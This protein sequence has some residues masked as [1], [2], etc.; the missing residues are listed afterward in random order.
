MPRVPRA[1]SAAARSI[2][3]PRSATSMTRAPLAS[4][5]RRRFGSAEG[6]GQ[7]PNRR[8]A[9]FGEE[10]R[11]R[12]DAQLPVDDDPHRRA[13]AEPIEPAG[14]L[15]VVGEHGADANHDRIVP[16]AQ[17]MR[18]GARR[19]SGN[20]AA[21]APR[22]RDPPV[23]RGRELHRDERPAPP[24]PAEKPGIDLGR[25]IGA[26]PD[27]G[28]DPGG[29]QPLDPAAAD[30]RIR[31]FDRGDDPPDPGFDQR[32][33]ARR[34]LAPVAARFE[35]DIGGG[36]AGAG[37]GAGQRLGLGVRPAARLGPA[38]AD[39]ASFVDQNAADRRVGPSIAE[40]APGEP[41]CRPHM[42]KI[43]AWRRPR[44]PP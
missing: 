8:R 17:Q 32:L 41:Q 36:A 30:A 33:G 35:A 1:A 19:R 11:R 18:P 3:S 15:R 21:L 13:P 40:A 6:R 43:A 24:Y 37:A 27:F 26:E 2:P 16:G 25:R 20:P 22:H 14:E 39:D 23:E 5:A 9:G 29:A 10:P 12:R 31:V 28:R 7:Q 4:S 34:R 44:P 42:A 38:A